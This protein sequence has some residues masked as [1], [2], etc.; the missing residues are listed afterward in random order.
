MRTTAT[1]RRLRVLLTGI[2]NGSLVPRPEFQRRLV[3]TTKDKR[4]FL[5]T[6]VSGYPFPEIYVAAGDVNPDTGEGTE[7]LVDGQQRITTLYEYFVGSPELK[8]GRGLQPYQDL[9]NESKIRFLEYDVVVRDLGA[10]SIDKITEVFARL[11]ATAY[12]LN[13]MEMHNAR[14]NG[15][16]KQFGERIAQDAFFERHRVF[17]INEV[18]RMADVRFALTFIITIMSTYFNRDDALEKYLETYNDNFDS[19]QDL[20]KEVQDVFDFIEA[21]HFPAASRA[22]KRSDVFTLLVETH[23]ARSKLGLELDPKEVGS[24]LMAFYSAVDEV[25][26]TADGR[27]ELQ[28]YA[29]ASVQATND[30]SSRIRRGEIVQAVIQAV[31]LVS[32]NLSL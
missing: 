32:L 27:P 25:S 7:L 31:P 20:Y 30:R 24:R 28:A 18:R 17:S 13:A 15:A 19:E 26:E 23:R 2:R 6:V 22:W 4:S 1:N 3:W 5:D 14:Y 9:D 10:L 16:F 21:C 12:S 29:L 11:N 8:L